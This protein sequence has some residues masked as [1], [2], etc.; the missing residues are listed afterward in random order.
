VTEGNPFRVPAERRGVAVPPGSTE[1]EQA[2]Q[3]VLNWHSS[4]KKEQVFRLF[5]PAGTGKTTLARAI[6]SRINGE[7]KFAAFSGKA[8]SVMRQKGCAG[9]STIHSLIYTPRDDAEKIAFQLNPGSPLQAASLLIV[10]EIS[11][12]DAKLGRDLLSYGKPILVLGDPAQLPPRKGEGFFINCRPDVQL[13]EIH[14]Q[15]QGDPIV[16]IA[17]DTRNGKSLRI[18]EYGS[19]RILPWK[20]VEIDALLAADQI[21]V[22]LNATRHQFNTRLRQIRGYPRGRPIVGDKLVCLRNNLKKRLFNGEIWFV[23]EVLEECPEWTRMEIR[24][25]I[26]GPRR[27]TIKVPRNFFTDETVKASTSPDQFTFGD[28]LTVHKSQ[29]SEW[30]NVVLFDEA[31]KL[32]SIPPAKWRYTGITRASESLTVYL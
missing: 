20:S 7:V 22:G 12:V 2:L 6:A 13:T 24:P 14:R 19:A 31:S 27:G 1:Q 17:T 11:N 23:T 32:A 3:A 5:G 18:G 30:K 16:Q 10:D 25:E 9:A 26:E 8:A 28:A 15:T 4:T 29:G 21:L